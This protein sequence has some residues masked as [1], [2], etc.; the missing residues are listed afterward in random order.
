[1]RGSPLLCLLPFLALSSAGVI[2]PEPFEF[3]H[4]HCYYFSQEALAWQDARDFC[5]SLTTTD[6]ADLAVFDLTCEDY[7]HIFL[8]ADEENQVEYW[9]GGTDEHHEGFWTWLDGRPIDL[10]A[11]YWYDE[12]PISAPDYNCLLIELI[13]EVLGRWRLGNVE[14]MQRFYFICQLGVEARQL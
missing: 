1:M 3:I 4:E 8:R 9:V 5:K 10:R 14:C 7:K 11:S 6:H 2:C 13:S 12:S